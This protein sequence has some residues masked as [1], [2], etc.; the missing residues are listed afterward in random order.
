MYLDC[1]WLELVSDGQPLAAYLARPAMVSAPLPA[2]VVV[3]EI[4][5]VDPHIQDVAARF[6]VAGY[7]ALAPDFYSRGG[8]L[9]EL[10]TQRIEAAK[11]FLD[12]VPP[13]SWFDPTARTQALQAR[14]AAERAE[15]EATLGR[16]LSPQRPMEQWLRDLRAAA[17]YLQASPET[18][19]RRLGTVGFCMGGSLAAQLAIEEPLVAAAVIFYGSSPTP[20]RA[21]RVHCPLLG[22]YGADDPRVL[23]TVQPFADA[24]AAA[25]KSFDRHVYAQTGHAFFNDT[26]RSYRVEAARDAWART[27]RF[28]SE[29][30]TESPA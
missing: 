28:F 13:P 17:V 26:R 9:P 30:L 5:G 15:L 23:A 3:Q 29:N 21:A 19:G 11:S 18:A 25:G 22:F 27:L 6:A 14:P 20:E 10:A 4:W 7:V 16:L 24:L 1:R 2:I 8:R 12:S